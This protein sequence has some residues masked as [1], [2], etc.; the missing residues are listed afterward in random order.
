V[1]AALAAMIVAAVLAPFV[2]RPAAPSPGDAVDALI[3]SFQDGGATAPRARA[4][5]SVVM[6]ESWLRSYVPRALSQAV[7]SLV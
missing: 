4:V 1:A 6:L 5:L 3:Q 7:P 2:R